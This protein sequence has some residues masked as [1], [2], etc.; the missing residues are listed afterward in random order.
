M[1]RFRLI[2]GDLEA[3]MDS[4]PLDEAITF[5]EYRLQIVA[6]WPDSDTKKDMVARIE[7]TLQ[8]LREE[9][10]RMRRAHSEPRAELQ[11]SGH[12]WLA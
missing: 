7:R 2:C 3:H 10:V 5:E 8:R 4:Q 9:R 12:G 11:H 6:R 1:A